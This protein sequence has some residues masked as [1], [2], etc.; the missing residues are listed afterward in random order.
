MIESIRDIVIVGGGT[1]GWMTAAALSKVLAGAY[2]IP[3]AEMGKSFT[4]GGDTH[5][6]H[7]S[8]A[9]IA[10]LLK[11]NGQIPSIPDFSQTYDAQFTEALA[12]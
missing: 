5:S 8:G 10:K 3:L 9:I 1:A 6:F 2:N 11:D 12:Q 7:G 4:P